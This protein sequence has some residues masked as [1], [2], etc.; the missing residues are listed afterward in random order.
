MPE[1]THY[2]YVFCYSNDRHMLATEYEEIMAFCQSNGYY[3]AVKAEDTNT[4]LLTTMGMQ[5]APGKVH[6]HFL[7]IREKATFA[8]D[9]NDRRYGAVKKSHLRELFFKKCPAIASAV[10]GSMYAQKYA[11]L[12]QQMTSDHAAVYF[13]KETLLKASHL[14][15][16]M[17]VI[18]PYISLKEERKYNPE[19]DAHEAAYRKMGYP[20]PA[21]F[22]DVWE[23]LN[24][25]WY[26]ANDCKRV[27]QEAHAVALADNLVAAINGEPRP[28]PKC[29]QTGEKR[30]EISTRY[31]PRCP[32][33]KPGGPN[34]LD[35][36]EQFCF[37]CKGY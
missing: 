14:P 13:S 18:R 10:S 19:D 31:C 23:Y 17:V 35:K 5:D 15:E 6:C 33:S 36:R 8:H 16:D 34:T 3:W 20:E 4:D 22:E 24:H 11:L 7:I 1:S 32:A 12:C 21:S 37:Q 27:K 9:T 28:V 26:I 2:A 29:R 30:K 25:R